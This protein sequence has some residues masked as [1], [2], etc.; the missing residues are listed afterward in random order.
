MSFFFFAKLPAVVL[1]ASLWWS[2]GISFF[3]SSIS[4]IGHK[5]KTR[6][7]FDIIQFYDYKFE[8]FNFKN[9]YMYFLFFF[10]FLNTYR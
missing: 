2:S 1:A 5:K 6:F 8:F 7:T 4:F 10:F 9:F 3:S